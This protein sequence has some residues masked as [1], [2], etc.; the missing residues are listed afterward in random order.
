M[1]A[2]RMT[3]IP[4]LLE[5]H[6]EELRFLWERRQSGLGSPT[7]TLRCFSALEERIVGHAHGLLVAQDR[8]IP[9]LG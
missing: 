6:Y 8:V 5:V 2:P 9:L 3:Y 1:T 7:I 4:D